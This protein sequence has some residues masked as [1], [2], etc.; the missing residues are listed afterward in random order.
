[1]TPTLFTFFIA[2]RA[3]PEALALQA[4]QSHAGGFGAAAS[5]PEGAVVVLGRPGDD[6]PCC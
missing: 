2:E 3:V 4:V 6:L 5:S 1:M